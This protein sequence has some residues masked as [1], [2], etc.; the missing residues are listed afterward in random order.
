MKLVALVTDPKATK[1]VLHAIGEPTEPPLRA[2]NAAT[3]S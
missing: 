2:S 3:T 1:R